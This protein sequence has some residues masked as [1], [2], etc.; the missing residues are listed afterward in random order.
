MEAKDM[1]DGLVINR[2]GEDPPFCD[3]FFFEKKSQNVF[4]MEGAL[5]ES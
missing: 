3:R 4:L 5:R 2:S 1:V